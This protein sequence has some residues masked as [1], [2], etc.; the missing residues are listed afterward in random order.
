M[1]DM[2][3]AW[4]ETCQSYVEAGGNIFFEEETCEIEGV[5]FT[6]DSMYY[7][8]PVCGEPVLDN[9]LCDEDIQAAHLAYVKAR[10][11]TI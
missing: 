3:R 1:R 11:E 8:C 9:W 2:G 4:C 10:N 6:Y 7:K 5:K